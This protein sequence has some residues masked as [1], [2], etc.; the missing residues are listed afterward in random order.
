[1]LRADDTGLIQGLIRCVANRSFVYTF[2][3]LLPLGTIGW[4]GLPTPWIFAS[5]GGAAAALSMGAWNNAGVDAVP[6]VFNSLGPI[7]S[8][9]VAQLLGR[10]ESA[11]RRIEASES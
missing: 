6:S 1:V 4:K 11:G 10:T 9:S 5:L 2:V 7:L 3:W 8:L